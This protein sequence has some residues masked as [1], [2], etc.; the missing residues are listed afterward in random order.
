MV[1]PD[2]H[3]EDRPHPS[4]SVVWETGED[5][6]AGIHAVETVHYRTRKGDDRSP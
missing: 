2:A 4:D 6:V 1:L 3:F 5:I